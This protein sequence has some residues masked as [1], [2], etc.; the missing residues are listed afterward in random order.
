MEKTRLKVQRG[1][2][3]LDSKSQENFEE[4]KARKRW[5]LEMMRI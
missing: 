3:T 2:S 5:S 1:F 4:S